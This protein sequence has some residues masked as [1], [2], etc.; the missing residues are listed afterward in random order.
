MDINPL[1]ELLVLKFFY[2]LPF[3]IECACDAKNNK[4]W[5]DA[6][7]NSLLYNNDMDPPSE[8]NNN[9]P[10]E[11]FTELFYSS[12]TLFGLFK[13]LCLVSKIFNITIYF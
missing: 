12:D 11:I 2:R 3:E 10:V 1:V 9:E 8:I 6:D 13:F 5:Y 4:C 7:S